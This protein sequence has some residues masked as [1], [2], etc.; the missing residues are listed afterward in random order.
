MFLFYTNYDQQSF[1][2]NCSVIV[3]AMI[4]QYTPLLHSFGSQTNYS[5][6]LVTITLAQ[7]DHLG[8]G[9]ATLSSVIKNS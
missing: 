5:N 9:Y 6:G 1:W 3:M 7:K 2:S 8:D 4:K